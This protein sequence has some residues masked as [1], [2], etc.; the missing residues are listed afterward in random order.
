MQHSQA[1]LEQVTEQQIHHLMRI[2]ALIQVK[3]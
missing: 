2:I 1:G 3:T